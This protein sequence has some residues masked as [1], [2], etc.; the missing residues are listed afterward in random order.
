MVIELENIAGDTGH[1][2][3]LV[4]DD[5][6]YI[7]YTGPEVT[8]DFERLQQVKVKSVMPCYFNAEPNDCITNA[9]LFAHYDEDIEVVQGFLSLDDGPPIA[10]FHYFNRCK[11]TGQ[12]WDSTPMSQEDRLRY[13]YWIP[14]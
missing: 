3:N 8:A 1:L 12:Y 10:I 13:H 6:E 9:V 11:E 2:R 5:G 7:V 4:E 14:A